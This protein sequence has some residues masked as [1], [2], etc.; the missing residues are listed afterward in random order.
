MQNFMLK[1]KATTQVCFPQGLFEKRQAKGQEG[2]P[3][4][5]AMFV[6]PKSDTAKVQQIN[7]AF[8]EAFKELQGKGFKGKTAAAIDPK[9]C[10]LIDG[11]A[12][13]DRVDGKEQFR[14]YYV[15][16]VASKN[17]RPIVTDMQQRTIL[18]G[19]PFVGSYDSLNISDETLN[20]GDHVLINISFWTY[21]NPTASGIGCNIHAVVRVASGEPFGGAS[22]N[23]SDYITIDPNEAYV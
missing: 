9:N 11:D 1:G 6:I 15:L 2:E 21:C 16:R 22:S 23:V 13:A 20:D 14:G 4:Y 3:K 18:N 17:F 7:E 19:V 10:C 12:W 5:N 8:A